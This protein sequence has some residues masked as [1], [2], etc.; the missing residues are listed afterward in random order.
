MGIPTAIP[1]DIV[2]VGDLYGSVFELINAKSLQE[3]I[4]DGADIDSL[5]KESVD[6][7]KIIHSTKL[8]DEELPSKREEKNRMRKIL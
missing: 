2:K 3:L 5:V 4:I 1:Y 8:K 7:L 6:V